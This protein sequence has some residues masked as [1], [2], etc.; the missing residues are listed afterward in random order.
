M[1]ICFLRN[2]MHL[3][4]HMYFMCIYIFNFLWSGN[5]FVFFLYFQFFCRSYTQLTLIIGKKNS[6][7]KIEKVKMV[8]VNL[9]GND[10]ESETFSKSL[11]YFPTTL[12][13]CVIKPLKQWTFGIYVRMMLII[14]NS[15]ITS[16]NHIRKSFKWD[17]IISKSYVNLLR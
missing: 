2:F 11:L 12:R 7:E 10:Y 4:I 3:V 1:W 8:R 6:S 16:A 15:K 9:K 5:I 17:H 13:S 14:I